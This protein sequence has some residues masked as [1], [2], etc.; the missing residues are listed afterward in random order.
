MMIDTATLADA[1][2]L[3]T[4]HRTA[5]QAA[6][7]WLPVLHTPDQVVWFFKSRVLPVERVWVARDAKQ[8]AGF[9]AVH[10][11]WL[12]HLYIDP[13]HWGGGWGTKLLD[14]A[15]ADT[16]RLQLRVF[17]Q[18]TRARHF[19]ACRGFLERELTDGQNNEEGMPDLRM[20]WIRET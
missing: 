10:E 19:Y 11:G 18:N 16:G 8:I 17:Q 20:E 1:V 5:R 7:P 2:G 15:R 14:V 13:G 3:A 12:N 9:I 6:M 4:L